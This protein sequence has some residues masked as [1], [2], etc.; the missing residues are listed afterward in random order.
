MPGELTRIV[1]KWRID[2]VF[3]DMRIEKS[4]RVFSGRV[5]LLVDLYSVSIH[6]DVEDAGFL[7]SG[8]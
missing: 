2:G 4:G 6:A 8:Q 7:N 5:G 3:S 1:S